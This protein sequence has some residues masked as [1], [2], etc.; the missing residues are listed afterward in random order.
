MLKLM[1]YELRKQAFSKV[2]ILIMFAVFELFFLYAAFAE[3]QESIEKS[4]AALVVLAFGTILFVSFESIIT[5]SNDLKTKCSYMLFM[6]PHSSYTIVG[7]KV[8]SSILQIVIT[9]AAYVA[10]GFAD[11]GILAAKNGD[12]YKALDVI[13]KFL[14]VQIDSSDIILNIGSTLTGWIAVVIFAF[15]AITISTTL[16]SNKRGKGCVSII[17]FFAINWGLGK[18]IRLITG[19]QLFYTKQEAVIAILVTLICVGIAYLA[20]SYMLEEKINL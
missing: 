8:L 20:T 19:T 15:L 12:L 10:I 7:A 16:F 9:T 14:K 6:T 5:Y 4:V 17:I 11:F 2:I 3:K 1:K 18:L 13:Q